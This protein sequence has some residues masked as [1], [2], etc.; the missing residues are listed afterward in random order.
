[1]TSWAKDRV[2]LEVIGT[3]SA[4]YHK[5]WTSSGWSG[6][7]KLGGTFIQDPAALSFANQ[8]LHLFGLGSG[9]SNPSSRPY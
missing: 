6:Y 2:D 8:K 5:W 4:W 9:M 3:D 7:E 1:M